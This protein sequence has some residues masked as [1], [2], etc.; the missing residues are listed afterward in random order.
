MNRVINIQLD[1]KIAE[2]IEALPQLKKGVN[3]PLLH[4]ISLN[5]YSKN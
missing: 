1:K 5:F 2:P 3:I 4:I